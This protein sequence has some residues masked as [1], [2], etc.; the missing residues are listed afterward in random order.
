MELRKL[1]IK[2][3][4]EIKKLILE[5]FSGEPWNDTWTDEQL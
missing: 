5:I 3:I 1:S 2:N 4:E